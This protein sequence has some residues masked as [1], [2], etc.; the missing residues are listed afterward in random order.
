[1]NDTQE[2]LV[3]MREK[4]ARD[5]LAM[6]LSIPQYQ[7][8][9]IWR[10][11]VVKSFLSDIEK[12]VMKNSGAADRSYHLGCII[13]KEGRG[14]SGNV[15]YA[16]VDGQQRLITLA[17]WARALGLADGE[18]RLVGRP[19]RGGED[20][21]KRAREICKDFSIELKDFSRLELSVLEISERA[22]EE[23]AYAFFDNTNTLGKK[24]SDYDLLKTHHLRF[25]HDEIDDGRASRFC[26][27]K[28]NL[29]ATQNVRDESLQKLLLNDCLYRIR[30]WAWNGGNT[31]FPV[32]GDS[33]FRTLYTHFSSKVDEHVSS[34]FET[35]SPQ[36]AEKMIVGGIPFFEYVEYFRARYVQFL[37]HPAVKCLHGQLAGHSKGV[38]Y[39]AVLATSF[40]AY[41]RFGDWYLADMICA[42]AYVISRMRCRDSVQER[43][44][45]W[46]SDGRGEIAGGWGGYMNRVTE[47]VLHAPSD[48]ALVE[49]LH[50]DG[51]RY[52]VTKEDKP[53]TKQWYWKSLK[54]FLGSCPDRQGF[55]D[56]YERL[57][58]I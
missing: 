58:E 12:W 46:C 25:L 7:R 22:D 8:A 45:T 29:L 4:S 33:F 15:E 54:D 19:V 23:L 9:Y 42:L 17:L 26:A 57:I 36:E 43:M 52:V 20:A 24:L 34:S 27:Q 47:A 37:K 40:I 51:F 30:Q 18:N 13:L 44:L 5:V 2:T 41:C 16:I 3:C 32:N 53:N 50:G 10:Q 31:S 49:I 6:E 11:S 28:W 38:I 48:V 1:M 21:I 39:K 14:E 35:K 56:Y 55:S